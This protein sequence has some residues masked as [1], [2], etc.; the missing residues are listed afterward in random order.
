[1]GTLPPVHVTFC[2]TAVSPEPVDCT[3]RVHP[4]DGTNE[5]MPNPLGTVSTILWW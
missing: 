4:G 5:S 1:M 2:T 3:C